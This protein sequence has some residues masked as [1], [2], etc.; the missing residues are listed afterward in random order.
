MGWWVAGSLINGSKSDRWVRE[1]LSEWMSA[2]ENSLRFLLVCQNLPLALLL[3]Q[4]FGLGWSDELCSVTNLINSPQPGTKLCS[5]PKQFLQLRSASNPIVSLI[6]AI[7]WN[8]ASFFLLL[9]FFAFLFSFTLSSRS[10]LISFHEFPVCQFDKME[11]SREMNLNVW[12]ISGWE[13]VSVV[14]W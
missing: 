5:P 11:F 14:F 9:F 12:K 1:W 7:L 3:E 10:S 8:I 4:L 13:E 6:F 2:F